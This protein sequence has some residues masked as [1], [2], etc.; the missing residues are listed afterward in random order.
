M[1]SRKC[2]KLQEGYFNVQGGLCADSYS[3]KSDPKLQ[4]ERLYKAS[5]RSSVSNIHPNDVVI[6]SGCPLV[7]KNFKLFRIAS[8]LM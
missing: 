2:H 6:Q 3:E 1:T 8:I 4:S 7:S 5:G